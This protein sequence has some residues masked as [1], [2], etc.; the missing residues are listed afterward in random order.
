[1]SADLDLTE[2]IAVI[3]NLLIIFII[4]CAMLT[5]ISTCILG[6]DEVEKVPNVDNLINEFANNPSKANTITK[7][8]ESIEQNKVKNQ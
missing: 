3:L 6:S 5:T 7:T 4:V 1:M 2:Y 8:I